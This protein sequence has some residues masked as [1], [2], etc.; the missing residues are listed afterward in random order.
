MEEKKEMSECH[1]TACHAVVGL[2]HLPSRSVLA[3]VP[4]MLL[5]GVICVQSPTRGTPLDKAYGACPP[6][7]R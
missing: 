4:Y 7:L 1:F 2:G 3:P 6:L 5:H